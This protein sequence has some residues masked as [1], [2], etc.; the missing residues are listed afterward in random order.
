MHDPERPRTVASLADLAAAFG[1]N[2]SELDELERKR[3]VA[4]NRPLGH[5]FDRCDSRGLSEA[6]RKHSSRFSDRKGGA[7]QGP[8]KD[9]S[10]RLLVLI[11]LASVLS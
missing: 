2:M 9:A 1:R 5:Y 6:H 10:F 3:A 4:R 11:D 7:D 8:Q